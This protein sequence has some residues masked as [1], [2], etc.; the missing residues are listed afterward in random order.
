M[1]VEKIKELLEESKIKTI[2]NIEVLEK[3]YI[4]MSGKKGVYIIQTTDNDE[5]YIRFMFLTFWPIDSDDEL[6]KAI[7]ASNYVTNKKKGVKI[8]V[9]DNDV[10]SSFE[11]FFSCEDD[12]IL[13]FETIMRIIDS[14]V[15][16]F[17]KLMLG[18]TEFDESSKNILRRLSHEQ[19]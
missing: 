7:V 17:S 1:N 9:Q 6:A 4:R 12:F 11:G 5:F 16:M 3:D 19:G 13:F 8:F 14:S 2:K 10:S 18:E 15:S